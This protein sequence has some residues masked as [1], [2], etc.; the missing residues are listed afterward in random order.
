[1]TSA[2]VTPGLIH[3]GSQALHTNAAVLSWYNPQ[4]FY[5]HPQAVHQHFYNMHLPEFI[6][7][8][9]MLLP[10]GNCLTSQCPHILGFQATI[11]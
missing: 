6:Y 9:F 5:P 1:V 10:A 2:V 7:I 3:G 11:D 4:L 8:Y